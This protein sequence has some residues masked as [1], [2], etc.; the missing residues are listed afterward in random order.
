MLEHIRVLMPDSA[1]VFASVESAR[2]ELHRESNF[3]ILGDCAISGVAFH[4]VAYNA[5][6]SDTNVRRLLLA[7]YPNEEAATESSYVTYQRTS[8]CSVDI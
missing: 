8:F 6:L 4:F 5:L 2:V 7:M 1:D 3:V